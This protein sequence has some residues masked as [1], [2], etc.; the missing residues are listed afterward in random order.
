MNRYSS[1]KYY[2][3][4]KNRNN[5]ASTTYICRSRE[6]HKLMAT[7]YQKLSC[8]CPA[9]DCENERTIDWVHSDCGARSELNS[10]ADL[11]CEKHTDTLQCILNWRFSCEKHANEFREVDPLGLTFSLGM[12]R[13][14]AKDVNDK[15]WAARLSKKVTEKV[16]GQKNGLFS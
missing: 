9:I 1:A 16:M 10:D 8:P 4:T 7:E 13:S 12:M 14:M 15:A 3:M 2:F 5:I 11:R 6:L